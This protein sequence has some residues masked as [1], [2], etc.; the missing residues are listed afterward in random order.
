M[1]VKLTPIV[2]VTII[3]QAAFFKQ[4]CFMQFFSNNSLA[5]QFFGKIISAQKLRINFAQID[6]LLPCHVM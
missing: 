4:E 2:N 6:T 3:L 1:L 5:L